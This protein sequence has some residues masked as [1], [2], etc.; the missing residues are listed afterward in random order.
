QDYLLSP[1]GPTPPGCASGP[2]HRRLPCRVN[3]TFKRPGTDTVT[4]SRIGAGSWE[5]SHGRHT[6]NAVSVGHR[7]DRDLL[8]RLLGLWQVDRPEH[9]AVRREEDDA[10]SH[11][12]G[13]GRIFPGEPLR[14]VG[15]SIQKRRSPRPHP[16]SV[17]W[18]HLRLAS[19]SL[20]DHRWEFLHWVAAGLWLDDAL[21]PQ[22]RPL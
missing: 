3:V 7:N 6:R 13:R 11:V 17:H 8:G 19:R 20:V 18:H 2:R 22:G 5:E 9:L 12:H 1:C 21:G 10:R 4:A 15:L 16:G 14:P